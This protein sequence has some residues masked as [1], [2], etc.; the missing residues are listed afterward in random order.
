MLNQIKALLGDAQ[1]RQQIK[2]AGTM[3]EAISIIKSFGT[4]KGYQF[5]SDSISQLLQNQ[6][7][8]LSEEDLL[9]VAGGRIKYVDPTMGGDTCIVDCN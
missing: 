2:N 5:S 7:K 4:T 8:P 6:L 9:A 1:L 3:T